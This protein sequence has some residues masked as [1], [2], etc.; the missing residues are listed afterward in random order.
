MGLPPNI[1]GFTVIRFN[2]FCS[3]IMTGSLIRHQIMDYTI[4]VQYEY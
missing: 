4:K 3:F 1:L 2:N